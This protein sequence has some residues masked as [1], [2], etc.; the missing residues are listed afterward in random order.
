MPNN[1]FSSIR[2]GIFRRQADLRFVVICLAYSL[3]WARTLTLAGGKND[4]FLQVCRSD[5]PAER[6]RRRAKT[7]SD[8]CQRELRVKARQKHAEKACRLCGRRF[9]RR[10]SIEAVLH[11]HK[12]V[13]G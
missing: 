13:N 10:R 7:C 9:I 8:P 1:Q 12:G 3:F 11:E 2:P 5:M 6:M 4:P